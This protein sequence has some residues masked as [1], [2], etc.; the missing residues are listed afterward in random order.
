MNNDTNQPTP[1][2]AHHNRSLVRRSLE[3]LNRRD[4]RAAG[5]ILAEDLVNHCA[6][7]EAQGRAG[8]VGIWE[9]LLAAF[10]DLSWTCE[11]LIAE[12]DRIVF[13]S[14]MRGTN[15]GPLRFARL[16]LPATNRPFDSEAIFIFRVAGGQIAEVWAQ[17]DELGMLRQLGHLLPSGSGALATADQASSDPGGGT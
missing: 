13:R 15:T 4:L 3:A 14:R 1:E 9:K 6:F 17:R 16:P 5:A 12:G 10:P 2:D 7:R 8:L 11:D